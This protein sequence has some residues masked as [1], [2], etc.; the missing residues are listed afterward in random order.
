MC[1]AKAMEPVHC[2]PREELRL[3]ERVHVDSFG[4]LHICQGIS[5]GNLIK[6]PL[7]EIMRNYDPDS[8][9]GH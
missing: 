5:I 6:Q 4:N 1:N 9:P 7:V 2:L 8:P 3:P